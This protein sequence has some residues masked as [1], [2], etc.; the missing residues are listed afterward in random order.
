MKKL[1]YLAKI[2]EVSQS[3]PLPIQVA[4]NH[5]ITGRLGD[6]FWA[7]E[8]RCPHI[9]ANMDRRLPQVVGSCIVCPFHFAHFDPF[10]GKFISGP[11]DTGDIK[12][13]PIAVEDGAIFWLNEESA[14]TLLPT[15]A[16]VDSE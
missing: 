5:I 8:R 4:D 16:L 13:F 1:V 9:N 10:T 11:P 2:E 3:R 7:I 14:G 15:Q 12:V 6:Q